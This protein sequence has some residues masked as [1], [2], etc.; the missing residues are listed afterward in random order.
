MIAW[1]ILKVS[2]YAL[3]ISQIFWELKIRWQLR[4]QLIDMT[5]VKNFF[6]HQMFQ[7]HY[8]LV[9]FWLWSRYI[10]NLFYFSYTCT[11]TL[12][13]ENVQNPVNPI[14]TQFKILQFLLHLL[15]YTWGRESQRCHWLT[16]NIIIP[17]AM[18]MLTVNKNLK[19]TD[20]D[21]VDFALVSV[22]DYIPMLIIWPW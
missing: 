13:F 20:S 8:C 22:H 18:I 21:S 12:I 19:S 15:K 3:P 17:W 1:S 16:T 7:R 2:L 14:L 9:K 5:F 10:I 11:G 6:A 4:F